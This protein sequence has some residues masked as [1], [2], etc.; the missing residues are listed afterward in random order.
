MIP[1][2]YILQPRKF[3]ES[4][5]S[6]FPPCTR[7]VWL[8]LLRNVNHKDNGK[9]S[10]GVGF[11]S[12]SGIRDVLCW[13]VGFCKKT[14]SKDQVVKALRRLRDSTMIATT[15][16]TRGFIVTIC[17]Y[18]FY[19]DPKNYEDTNDGTM[20]ASRRRCGSTTINK[21]VR[22]EEGKKTTFNVKNFKPDWISQNDWDDIIEHRKR[23][24]ASLTKRGLTSLIKELS[25]AVEQGFSVAD[26]VDK[27]TNRNWTGFEAIWMSGAQQQ[28]QA[29]PRATTVKQAQ[30]VMRDNI[31]K[32]LKE[33]QNVKKESDS[34]GDT[35]IVL[36]L[37]G[38]RPHP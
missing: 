17:N 37:P 7:E 21:N 34:E 28:S 10:R 27:M 35:Q 24:K 3:D 38:S 22:M 2:G 1:G 29:A 12:I 33:E 20:K 19:Q 14:Y 18:D 31:A 26:C 4:E 15:K 36:A 13:Y 25:L 6:N 30:A 32:F 9:L 11:F 8:Y 5:S 23:K 16:T